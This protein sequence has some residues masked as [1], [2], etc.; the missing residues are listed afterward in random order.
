MRKSSMPSGSRTYP[1]SGPMPS[2]PWANC[3]CGGIDA[4]AIA[5]C[6]CPIWT[7]EPKPARQ[8]RSPVIR[9]LRYARPDDARLFGTLRVPLPTACPR[10]GSARTSIA[11]LP[12]FMAQLPGKG[13]RAHSRKLP[14]IRD[15][16]SLVGV[17][18]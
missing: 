2:P 16:R 1:S 4:D 17:G 7:R 8:V 11:I 9:T 18:K 15:F 12:A 3:K 5:V 10:S 13:T 6:L 14:E